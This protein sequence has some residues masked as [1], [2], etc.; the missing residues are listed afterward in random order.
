[1]FLRA[2]GIYHFLEAYGP[3]LSPRLV[4]FQDHER[5][6]RRD[7]CRSPAPR[8]LPAV[9]FDRQPTR[10][11]C[12]G[13]DWRLG[14]QVTAGAAIVA[15][16]AV[17]WSACARGATLNNLLT[18]IKVAAI[19]ASWRW[20]SC[21][22]P[23]QRAARRPDVGAGGRLRYRVGAVVVRRLVRADVRGG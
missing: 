17:N 15:L 16:T 10:F 20:R 14:G 18:V 6:D 12:S 2:G 8:Q 19:T 4:R 3:C 5:R 21:S 23:A 22:A 7:R 9:Q 1:M 11:R 13:V